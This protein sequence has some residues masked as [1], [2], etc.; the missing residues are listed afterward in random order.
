[1]KFQSHFNYDGKIVREMDPWSMSS[2]KW[3][4]Y[5]LCHQSVDQS[6]E[7]TNICLGF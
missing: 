3:D 1:M 5:A 2:V 7:N 4:L 6:V